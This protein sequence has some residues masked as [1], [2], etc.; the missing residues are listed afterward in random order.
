MESPCAARHRGASQGRVGDHGVIEEMGAQSRRSLGEGGLGRGV[1]H[2]GLRGSPG[3]MA[4]WMSMHFRGS[5]ASSLHTGVPTC[6][7][8]APTPVPRPSTCHHHRTWGQTSGL[9]LYLINKEVDAHR[10]EARGHSRQLNSQG[11]LPVT[12]DP[13][14]IPKSIL[15]KGAQSPRGS[16]FSP[17][18]KPWADSASLLRVTRRTAADLGSVGETGPALQAWKPGSAT[19]WARAQRRAPPTTYPGREHPW[20][21]AEPSRWC[22]LPSHTGEASP[23]PPGSS[24]CPSRF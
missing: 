14:Q 22:A 9:G 7:L 15:L 18:C 5:L 4:A 8:R 13:I 2:C 24:F 16:P 1:S 3:S 12:P 11:W 19:G 6:V 10:P 17:I 20:G 21:L 23:S